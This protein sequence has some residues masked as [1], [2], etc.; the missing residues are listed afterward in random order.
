[1]SVDFRYHQE[2]TPIPMSGRENR[3][4]HQCSGA[5]V[6][7]MLGRNVAQGLGG[8]VEHRFKV[9]IEGLAAVPGFGPAYPSGDNG[10]EREHHQRNRHLGTALVQVVLGLRAQ[11][12]TFP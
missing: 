6:P 3:E 4:S 7:N 1:M 12:G 8:R 9:A 5:E 10:K 2:A 11:R